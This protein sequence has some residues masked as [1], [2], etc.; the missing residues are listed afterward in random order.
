MQRQQL[1]ATAVVRQLAHGSRLQFDHHG[2]PAVPSAALRLF[3]HDREQ[4]G[5]RGVALPC[6]SPF[7]RLIRVEAQLRSPHPTDI[8]DQLGSGRGRPGPA[9]SARTAVL[10]S[11]RSKNRLPR[12]WYGMPSRARASSKPTVWAFSRTST[13]ISLGSTPSPISDFD[14]S[15]DPGLFLGIGAEGRARPARD[16][17]R[18]WPPARFSATGRRQ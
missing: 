13:A 1:H 6:L 16:H 7:R 15:H 11:R 14:P 17:P 2:V 9:R 18:P 8:G 3:G 5:E 12:S 10:T 4:R